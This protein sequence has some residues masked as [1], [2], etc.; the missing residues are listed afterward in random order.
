MHV[1]SAVEEQVACTAEKDAALD[2]GG[3]Q[4]AL[5]SVEQSARAADVKQVACAA[6]VE[7]W[8]Q[9]PV[10]NC[11]ACQC[12]CMVQVLFIVAATIVG[13]LTA[14]PGEAM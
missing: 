9:L 13:D 6:D 10:E 7:T 14:P 3:N 5:A 2:A 12:M 1:A 11:S 4:G 8:V